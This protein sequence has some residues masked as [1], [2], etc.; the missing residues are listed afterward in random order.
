M[1]W[2]FLYQI[3]A[4]SRT[5]EYWA[6]VPRS[7]FSL[8]S[9]LNWICWTPPRKKFLGTPLLWPKKGRNLP[10]FKT[11]L[12]SQ[13]NT[14]AFSF[15]ATCFGL[16][17]DHQQDKKNILPLKMQAAL[18]TNITIWHWL[19][20]AVLSTFMKTKRV[21]FYEGSNLLSLWISFVLINGVF[22][23]LTLTAFFRITSYLS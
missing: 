12:N 17:I 8:S 7:P 18:H 21:E 4:A 20:K 11:I 23:C 14:I 22:K 13:S 10:N 9:V 15:K 16:N 3:T 1:K 6:A 5:P 19:L 2:N